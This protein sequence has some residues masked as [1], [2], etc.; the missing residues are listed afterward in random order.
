MI[1]GGDPNGTG[2][3]GESIWGTPFKDEYHPKLYHYRG[4]LSMANSGTISNPQV[5]SYT[6]GSQFFIVQKSNLEDSEKQGLEYFNYPQPV[7]DNYSKV[8]GTMHLD[9]THTVFGQ[10]FK[11]MDVVDKIAATKVDTDTSKPINDIKT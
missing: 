5:R 9:N 2:T 6:N 7:I 10:V 11:G 3:G 4:A 8:G 1:Q